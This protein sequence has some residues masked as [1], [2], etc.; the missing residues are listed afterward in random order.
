MKL[1]Q[2][3]IKLFKIDVCPVYT[4]QT[5]DYE[6]SEIA[7][8]ASGRTTRL[9][10]MYI[11]LLFATGR[12]RVADHHGTERMSRYLVDIIVRRLQIEH[13]RVRLDV[14]G[15]IITIERRYLPEFEYR[16]GKGRI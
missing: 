8:R 11:Q 2:L 3:I 15:N 7:P 10:D 16:Y 6:N 13:S 4:I 12:I 9:A 14:S 1:K 5:I